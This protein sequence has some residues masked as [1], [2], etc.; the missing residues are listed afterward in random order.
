MYGKFL[1]HD[2]VIYIVLIAVS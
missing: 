1:R 2:K